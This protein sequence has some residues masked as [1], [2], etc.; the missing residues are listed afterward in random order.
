MSYPW[1]RA[2]S[3]ML[4]DPKLRRMSPSQRWV[5]IG[6]LCLASDAPERG[7]LELAPGVAYEI[8]DLAGTIG[9]EEEDVKRCLDIADSLGMMRTE[10]SALILVNWEKRQYDNP[11]D[12]PEQTRERKRNSTGMTCGRISS[13][14]YHLATAALP[15]RGWSLIHHNAR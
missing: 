9:A 6:L 5:W 14:L 3:E 2:Y 7:V 11:S 8:E 10:G 13:V 15:I 4:H 1:F 12:A